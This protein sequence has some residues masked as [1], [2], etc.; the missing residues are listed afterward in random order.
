MNPPNAPSPRRRRVLAVASGGGHWIQLRRLRPAWAGM[1]VTYV[2][3]VPGYADEVA[4]DEGS[5]A[6]VVVTDANRWQKLRLLRQLAETAW[7]VLRVRPHA[8]VTTGAA[9]GYFALRFARL[10]GA[11]TVWVDS[12]ANAEELSLSGRKAGPHAHLFL[13]QWEHLA[14]ADGPQFRGAVL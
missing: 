12:M 1:D 3:T 4:G 5:P 9:P 6:F 2:T 14:R 13:T 10:L 11:R 8:V 7:V